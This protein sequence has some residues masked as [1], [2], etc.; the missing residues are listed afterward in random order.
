MPRNDILEKKEDILQWI[1]NNES[2]AYI[3]RQLK[4]KPETL[5]SYLIKMGIEY[6]GNQGSK[7]KQAKAYKTAEEYVNGETVH[8]KSSLL[9][10]KLIRDGIKKYECECCGLSEWCGQPIPLELHHI[11]SNHFNNSFD[12]LEILC[13]NC[14]SLKTLQLQKNE[15]E[16]K[17]QN[18]AHKCM[19]CGAIIS[20]KAQRCKSCALKQRNHRI[21]K[22]R[23]DRTE[24]KHLIR[25]QSFLALSRKYGVSDNAIRKW[26]IAEGLPY[27]KSEINAYSDEEWA[28]I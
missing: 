2:K 10:E 18:M 22:E 24:L 25:N 19:D 12:N 4:C 20:A 13:S 21:V 28:L 9:K 7:G 11:D 5:N 17:K 16:I 3:C 14:H 27:K 23:P 15:I 26:C 8:I 1:E 6:A